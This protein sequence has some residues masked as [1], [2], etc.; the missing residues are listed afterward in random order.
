MNQFGWCSGIEQASLFAEHGF[1][2]IECALTSLQLED[3]QAHA[4]KLQQF[5]DAPLQVRAT[6]IFVPKGISVVGP[7][8]DEAR[9]QRYVYKAG[10]ALSALG[11]KVAVF[12][13]GNSRMIPEGW[14][15]QQA[16]AQM[17]HMLGTIS[18]EWSGN[19]VTLA[20]EPLNRKECNFINSVAEAAALAEQINTPNVKVLA[21]FYHMDEENEPLDT[22]IEHRDW[23]AHIHLADT[24]RFAPGTGSYPYER[25]AAIL[26]E[27]HYTGMLSA[28]CTLQGTDNELADSLTFMRSTFG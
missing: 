2:Y 6:N 15:H 23:I 14:D 26:K 8:V 25:F 7:H 20:I 9:I 10:A 22:I 19:G 1:D 4:E 28:E 11:V 17:L 27:I 21:D 13:S 12:G 3:E 16:E 5:Q 18:Q 24:G